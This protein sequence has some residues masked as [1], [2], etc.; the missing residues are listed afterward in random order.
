MA[1]FKFSN[2]EIISIKDGG[3]LSTVSRSPDENSR[4]NVAMDT[5]ESMILALDRSGIN[6]DS[7]KI[8]EAVETTF[9]F[10]INQMGED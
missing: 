1:T 3:M 8:K 5:F 10:L 2:K 4:W 9:D 7:P 6:M